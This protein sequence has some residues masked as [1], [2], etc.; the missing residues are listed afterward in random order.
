[1]KICPGP[2]LGD[3][4]KG[5]RGRRGV[6]QHG[7]TDMTAIFQR[8]EANISRCGVRT[9]A[10]V[11]L[12]VAAVLSTATTAMA[13]DLAVTQ[14]RRLAE[15]NCSKCHAVGKFGDSPLPIAP[16]FRTLHEK[17]PV[18]DL[19][20]SLAEGI[21]TGHPTMPQFRF[22]VDQIKN[23]IAYLKSLEPAPSRGG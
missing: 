7:M 5:R 3:W 14:G 1:M 10:F 19:E 8:S 11:G 20:E 17:Y 22:D 23:F 12:A 4:R 6:Q 13:E 18:E 16:P 15:A 9:S 2:A 21:S